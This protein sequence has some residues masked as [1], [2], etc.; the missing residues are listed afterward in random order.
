M[1]ILKIVKGKIISH[2]QGLYYKTNQLL[3][4]GITPIYIFDGKPP[5]I[6]RCIK[7]I[8]KKPKM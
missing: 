2:I 8:L 5:Q 1:I 4:F 6:K 7:A 3:T